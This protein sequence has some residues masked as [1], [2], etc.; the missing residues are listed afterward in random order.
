MSEVIQINPAPEGYSLAEIFI[1]G[2]DVVHVYVNGR[3]C[4]IAVG[5]Y[6]DPE[7]RIEWLAVSAP[8]E[9][10]IPAP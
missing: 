1:T 9:L 6:R 4:V 3:Q 5:W 7:N 10:K 2:K 8:T